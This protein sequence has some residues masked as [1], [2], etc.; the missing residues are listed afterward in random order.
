M[1]FLSLKADRKAALGQ[2]GAGVARIVGDFAQREIRHRESRQPLGDSLSASASSSPPRVPRNSSTDRVKPE[3]GCNFCRCFF[4]VRPGSEDLSS[5]NS[6]SGKIDGGDEVCPG[7]N[8]R[9]S[10]E[11]EDRRSPARRVRLPQSQPCAGGVDIR[12][13]VGL[14]DPIARHGAAQPAPLPLH[15]HVFLLGKSQRGGG[16]LIHGCHAYPEKPSPYV[17]DHS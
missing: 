7:I 13:A 17:P 6:S 14:D 2:A 3:G 15:R 12:D 8:V 9:L 5:T 16:R 1:G 11:P 4:S 10:G